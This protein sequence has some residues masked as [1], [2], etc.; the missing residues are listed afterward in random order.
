MQ[1]Q[2]HGFDFEDIIIQSLTGV[3]A[4]EYKQRQ[5]NGH[6]AIFDIDRGVL[7]KKNYSIKVSKQSMNVWTSDILRFYDSTKSTEFNMIVGCWYYDSK[8]K[9]F[10]RILEFN[11]EPKYHKFLWNNLPRKELESFCDYVKNIP[12]GSKAQQ[13]NK[14]V[15]KEKRDLLIDTYGKGIVSI[16]AKIDSGVQRRVQSGIRINDLISI[17]VKYKEYTDTFRNINLP[18]VQK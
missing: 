1:Y 5:K 17:G 9:E 8:G 15:W 6:T 12:H 14:Y 4:L 2:K 16:N 7:S 10:T 3:S 13:D 18:F 11:F